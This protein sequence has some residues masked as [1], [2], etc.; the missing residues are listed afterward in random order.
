VS[1]PRKP[2]GPNPPGRLQGTLVKV[3]A[4]ELSDQGRL[5]RGKRY[6]AD[7]AVVDIVVGHGSVTAEVMGSRP[8][9]YVVT[10]E[11][12]GGTG[13]PSKRDLWIRCS[14]PDDSGTGG[15][16]CKHAVAALFALSDEI[17]V[18]PELVDR[19]RAGGRHSRPAEVT[20]LRPDGDGTDAHDEPAADAA[21]D[22]DPDLAPVVPIRPASELDGLA[23]LLRSPGGESVVELPVPEP[24]EHPRLAS[25]LA[26]DVVEDVLD[27]LQ[28]RWE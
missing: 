3:L 12:E 10:I 11:A 18:Q 25:A 24:I 17:T 7:D 19:W 13:M 21:E 5:V 27:H 23:L 4:A 16:A 9:P 15:E 22:P 28:I 26:H 1:R 8:D 14:C 2:F 6:W 20:T